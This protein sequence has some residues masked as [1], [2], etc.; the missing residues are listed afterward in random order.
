MGHLPAGAHLREPLVAV[1]A[2]SAGRSHHRARAEPGQAATTS[3]LAAGRLLPARGLAHRPAALLETAALPELALAGT[4]LDDAGT[5]A[6]RTL[7]A[8]LGLALLGPALLAARRL[9]LADAEE[10]ILL[11]VHGVREHP[12]DFAGVAPALL[13]Q[14]S[15]PCQKGS[16]RENS[17]DCTHVLAF[18][19]EESSEERIRPP[20]H[21]LR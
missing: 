9:K 6:A 14:Q 18:P 12:C 5:A 3:L 20:E 2:R 8:R 4:A 1:A 13:C 11:I 10:Q 17:T 21:Q 19:T 15:G 16:T 7:L